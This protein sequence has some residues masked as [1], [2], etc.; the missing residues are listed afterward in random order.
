MSLSCFQLFE[1]QGQVKKE[2]SLRIIC[3]SEKKLS[4]R[5]YTKIRLLVISR[6]F[7][8]FYFTNIFCRYFPLFFFKCGKYKATLNL[9]KIIRKNIFI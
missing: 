6:S 1:K 5:T 3:F 9:K 2:K 4:S 7:I 8:S